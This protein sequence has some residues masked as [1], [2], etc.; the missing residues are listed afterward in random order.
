MLQEIRLLKQCFP[1]SWIRKTIFLVFPSITIK[2]SRRI[3]AFL[4]TKGE[5]IILTCVDK[6]YRRKGYAS[7]LIAKSKAKYVHT[8]K[9][10]KAA[11]S[12]YQK[13]GFIIA[14]EIKTPHGIKLKLVRER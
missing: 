7:Q 2:K 12:L 5:E 4:K 1:N 13:N 3:I 8:Y 14:K 11:I 6:N 9:E 10:N